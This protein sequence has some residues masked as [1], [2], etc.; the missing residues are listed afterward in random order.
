M[1]EP[2][3]S[4]AAKTIGD[5]KALAALTS[6]AE[7]AQRIAWAQTWRDARAWFRQQVEPLGLK[8]ETDAA[9]N[10]WVRLEGDSPETVLIG[11]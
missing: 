9:G 8:V 11:S 7:G 10:N 2:L 3:R 6:T 5:L 4:H 1:N